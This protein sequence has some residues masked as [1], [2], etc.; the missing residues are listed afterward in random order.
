MFKKFLRLFLIAA[1]IAVPV[2]GYVL[3][4]SGKSFTNDNINFF[5]GKKEGYL[6]WLEKLALSGDAN[7]MFRM[8]NNHRYGYNGLTPN[9]NETTKWYE[10]AI[11]NGD[12]D[13]T[14]GLAKMYYE[15]VGV[16]QD[17]KKAYAIFSKCAKQEKMSCMGHLGQMYHD[18]IGIEKDIEKA[19][20]WWLKTAEEGNAS[21]QFQ[22]G[23][24]YDTGKESVV[25]KDREQARLW[26]EKSAAQKDSRARRFLGY[27]YL[28]GEGGVEKDYLKAGELFA[29]SAKNGNEKA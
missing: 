19:F 18:G 10:L 17:Y 8:G 3:Y 5:L 29:L 25:E 27:M 12:I 11:E 26:Y 1:V 6:V 16:E 14:Y 22:I 2:S 4:K 7:A 21:A 23:Y 13:A 24:F 9:I 20:H 28:D 15:G